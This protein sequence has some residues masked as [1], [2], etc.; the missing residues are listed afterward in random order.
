MRELARLF[1]SGFLIVTCQAVNVYQIAHLNYPGSLTA[2]FLIS[3]IWWENAGRA[4]RDK[5]RVKQATYAIG[6]ACGTVF[7]MALSQWL[8]G[9]LGRS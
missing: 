6:A 4:A 8:A 7:G 9:N 2:G 1:L 3:W 5:S